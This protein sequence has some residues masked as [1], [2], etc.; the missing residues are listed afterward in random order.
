MYGWA[1]ASQPSSIRHQTSLV[2][3][4]RGGSSDSLTLSI[5]GYLHSHVV[6]ELI[7][8]KRSS[9]NSDSNLVYQVANWT[10]NYIEETEEEVLAQISAGYACCPQRLFIADEFP[11]LFFT[12]P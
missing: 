10:V 9:L 6:C 2:K 7:Q 5:L 4:N 1:D 8:S 3:R 11:R 12:Y